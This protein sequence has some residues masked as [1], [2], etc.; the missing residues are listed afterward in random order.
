MIAEEGK[1]GRKIGEKW[2]A[3]L[4]PF[5]SA[6][7][8]HRRG[9]TGAGFDAGGGAT[10]ESVHPVGHIRRCKIIGFTRVPMLPLVE[11]PPSKLGL[12]YRAKSRRRG[13]GLRGSWCIVGSALRRVAE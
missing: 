2:S 4:V 6:T 1:A 3:I 5:F 11:S 12:D 8:T 10:K 13:D 9:P 7:D